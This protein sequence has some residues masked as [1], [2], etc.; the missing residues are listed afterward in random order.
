ML[1]TVIL[2]DSI[3]YSALFADCTRRP[4]SASISSSSSRAASPAGPPIRNSTVANSNRVTWY[5]GSVFGC[6]FT[7]FHIVSGSSFH[8][9]DLREW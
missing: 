5:L 9:V 1:L 3:V 8:P 4:S 6:F 2:A 7:S